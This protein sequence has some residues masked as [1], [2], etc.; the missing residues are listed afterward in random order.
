M[1]DK[2]PESP[3]TLD[4]YNAMTMAERRQVWLEISAISE[5][6]FDAHMAKQQAREAIVPKVGELAPDFVAERL[7]RHRKRTGETVRL[8]DLRGK[9]AAIAFGSYT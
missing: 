2:T 8:S 7:D 5:A 4:A 1:L 9:P 3:V 6:E